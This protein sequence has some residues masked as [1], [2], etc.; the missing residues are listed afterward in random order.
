MTAILEQATPTTYS[1]DW[2]YFE[3]PAGGPLCL[4][5]RSAVPAYV[6][7]GIADLHL[8]G[9]PCTLVPTSA[10]KDDLCRVVFACGCRANVPPSTLD[11]PSWE[12]TRS[13]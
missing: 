3:P 8:F 11:P 9:Q 10:E 5:P 12:L 1:T 4:E 6:Y 7:R 13:A 2:D